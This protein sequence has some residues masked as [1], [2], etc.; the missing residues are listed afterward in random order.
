MCQTSPDDWIDAV[1]AL[2][3]QEE[4]SHFRFD[5]VRRRGFKMDFFTS[6][7]SGD[8]LHRPSIHSAPSTGSHSAHATSSRLEE[9]G[10]PV[11]QALVY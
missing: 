6:D 5:P 9:G 8:N 11:R 10:V 7:R 2:K 4:G 3:P 1:V